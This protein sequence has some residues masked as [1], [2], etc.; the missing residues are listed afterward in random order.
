MKDLIRNLKR[1]VYFQ[2]L[3]NDLVILLFLYDHRH[4]LPS[5]A[6]DRIPFVFGGFL[7]IRQYRMVRIR[8]T[9]YLSHLYTLQ[10][11]WPIPHCNRVVFND[12]KGTKNSRQV[13]STNE[14]DYNIKSCKMSV[15]AVNP[16]GSTCT[17]S[18]I[19]GICN[20]HGTD[21]EKEFHI[22]TNSFLLLISIRHDERCTV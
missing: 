8:S 21:L 17:K 10:A 2:C 3:R 12:R 9:Q 22:P 7:M 11:Q 1:R 15:E 4:R 20:F 13:I 19:V 18:N 14:H 16:V 5:C 6:N